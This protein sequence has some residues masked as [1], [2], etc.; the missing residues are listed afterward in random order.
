M[1]ATKKYIHNLREKS[2]LDIS[3][4][5]EKDILERFGKEPE[6]NEDGHVC[7]YTEQDVWEQ[8]RK[9]TNFVTVTK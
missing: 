8:I 9:M 7:E 3:E 5:I 2:F 6:K 1:I 4:E